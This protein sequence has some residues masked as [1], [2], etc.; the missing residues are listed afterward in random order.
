MMNRSK[1]I[2]RAREIAD[3]F[4]QESACDAE[5]Y[6]V[7]S[8]SEESDQE[9]AMEENVHFDDSDDDT[10]NSTICDHPSN[11]DAVY[12]SKNGERWISKRPTGTGRVKVAD[13]LRGKG[14]G[15][16]QKVEGQNASHELTDESD[17]RF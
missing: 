5:E 13:I 8:E 11:D 9:F 16:S 3:I 4:E 2:A 17:R 12:V 1:L 10:D 6:V 15:G 14:A 7:S